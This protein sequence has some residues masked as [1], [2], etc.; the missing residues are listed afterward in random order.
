Q[1]KNLVLGNGSTT[2]YRVLS[3]GKAIA[4][5]FFD[6]NYLDNASTYGFSYISDIWT[7][8]LGFY[9]THP[10]SIKI[11]NGSTYT[12]TVQGNQFVFHSGPNQVTF[13]IPAFGP[14]YASSTTY[15]IF[16][17]L[18]LYSSATIDADGVQV[19]KAFQEAIIAGI[20]PT[21]SLIDASTSFTLSSFK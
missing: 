14:P 16:S 21:T 20:L 17:G 6:Q 9:R 7:G 5:G 10:L 15:L 13:S 19:S 12:G 1:W 4:A 8:P 2:I 18:P 3:P 11:P